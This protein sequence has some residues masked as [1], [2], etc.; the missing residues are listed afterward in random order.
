MKTQLELTRNQIAVIETLKFR[1]AEFIANSVEQS[2]L[3]GEECC[4]DTRAKGC[5]RRIT[6][7]FNQGN[8]EATR[9]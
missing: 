8:R 7:M 3:N 9:K 2:W 6:K 5:P 4:I 1:K